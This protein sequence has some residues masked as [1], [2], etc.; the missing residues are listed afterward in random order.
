MRAK[1]VLL[2][3]GPPSSAKN[4]GV[5]FRSTTN[6]CATLSSVEQKPKNF[7]INS[8]IRDTF[9]GKYVWKPRSS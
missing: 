7:L 5:R 1:A 8:D 4:I 2:D 3:K 6:G 9:R